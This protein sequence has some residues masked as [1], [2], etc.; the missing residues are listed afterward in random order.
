M[1]INTPGGNI[2]YE[3]PVLKLQAYSIDEIFEK[4]LLFLLPFYI[5]C[6]E[7]KLKIYEKDKEMLEELIQEYAEILNRLEE[8]CLNGHINEYVNC[9]LIDMS[10]KVMNNLASKYENVKKGVTSVMGGKVLEH[11]A[12]TILR[13]GLSE[14]RIE[15]RRDGLVE[16]VRDGLLS[17]SEAA[18]RLNMNEEELRK[19]L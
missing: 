16:L 18:K 1:K 3:I 17:I 2:S 15:G 7:K 5:F 10:K 14:G 4:D 11:E 8:L 12:K 9:T 6:Y 13:K 19:Y